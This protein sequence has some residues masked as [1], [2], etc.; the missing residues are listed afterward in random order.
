MDQQS[1][2]MHW[3]DCGD[4]SLRGSVTLERVNVVHRA[5]LCRAWGVPSREDWKS[6][7]VPNDAA[8]EER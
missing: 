7:A 4:L 1:M 5:G 6:A 2:I 3:P 8:L